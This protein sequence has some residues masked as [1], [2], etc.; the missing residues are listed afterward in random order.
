MA[1]TH[2]TLNDRLF[3][4]VLFDCMFSA[5]FARS[6]SVASFSFPDFGSIAIITAGRFAAASLIF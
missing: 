2:K 6:I 3:T 1:G 4:K 5:E